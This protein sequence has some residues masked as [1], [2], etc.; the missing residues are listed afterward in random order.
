MLL[1]GINR[2]I[3]PEPGK[4]IGKVSGSSGSLAVYQ[5]RETPNARLLHQR[6]KGLVLRTGDKRL[7]LLDRESPISQNSQRAAKFRS[8]QNRTKSQNWSPETHEILVIALEKPSQL[9]RR[10][11]EG[12]EISVHLYPLN[13]VNEPVDSKSGEKNV[14]RSDEDYIVHLT[15]PKQS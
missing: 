10:F 1:S 12:D 8:K 5:N 9:Q 3:L 13:P 14:P 15:Q 6:R 11:I 4:S 2:N 7:G